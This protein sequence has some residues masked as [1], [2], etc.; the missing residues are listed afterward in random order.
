MKYYLLLV[1]LFFNLFSNAQDCILYTKEG[2]KIVV[3]NYDQFG[4]YKSKVAYTQWNNGEGGRER[5][6][7]IDKIEKLEA[8]GITYKTY[9]RNGEKDNF[10]ARVL[11]DSPD[12]KLIV[13]YFR[14]GQNFDNLFLR[15]E[16]I[17]N[18]NNLVEKAAYKLYGTKP[19]YE[20][21]DLMF[22]MVKKY[23]ANCTEVNDSIAHFQKLVA[24][25][26]IEE[27]VAFGFSLQNKIFTCE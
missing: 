9:S 18:N 12:K 3:R 5:Y 19:F 14:W 25:D 7:H 1:F 26:K 10:F 16:I 15:H 21:Q 2:E 22:A 20:K 13:G 23:F 27:Y 4:V 24:T 6:I 17:D 11:I 8:N